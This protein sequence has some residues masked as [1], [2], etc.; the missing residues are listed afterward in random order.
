MDTRFRPRSARVGSQIVFLMGK[1]QAVLTPSAQSQVTIPTPYRKLFVLRC[2]VSTS[3]I[4]AGSSTF[5]G[6]V[7]KE[8]ASGGV[9]TLSNLVDLKAL[10]VNQPIDMGGL[11]GNVNTAIVTDAHRFINEGD[12]LYAAVVAGGTITTQPTGLIFI[13]EAAVI[14]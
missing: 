6:S 1:A 10:T 3:I 11:G 7:A 5:V 4:P 12:Q 8:N 2:T 9:A 13:I 14:E